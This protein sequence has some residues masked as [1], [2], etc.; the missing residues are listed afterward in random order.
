MP[1]RLAGTINLTKNKYVV[2]TRKYQIYES[3]LALTICFFTEI[4]KK[5][6]LYEYDKANVTGKI[7]TRQYSFEVRPSRFFHFTR[8]EVSMI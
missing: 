8:E 2:N 5:K 1:A 7:L 3:A 4:S 6:Y